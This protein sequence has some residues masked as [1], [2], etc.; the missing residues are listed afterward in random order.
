[1]SR[2]ESSLEYPHPMYTCEDNVWIYI[3]LLNHGK[4]CNC[5]TSVNVLTE[6]KVCTMKHEVVIKLVR[7]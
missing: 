4:C 6:N 2:L 1:M 5:L 3:S 7:L